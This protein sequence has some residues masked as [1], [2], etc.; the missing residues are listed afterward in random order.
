M[1]KDTITIA[2][3]WYKPSGKIGYSGYGRIH[4]ET[5]PWEY[6]DILRQIKD[7]QNQVVDS[8]FDNEGILRIKLDEPERVADELPYSC[9][10]R[11][12]FLPLR[13]KRGNNAQGN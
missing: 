8:L 3:E 13:Q 4:K 12:L 9:Y 1:E 11:L 7:T 10:H 2:W 5:P 6:A